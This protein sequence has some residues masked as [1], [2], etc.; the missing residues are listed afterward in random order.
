MVLI[1]ILNRW[2]IL[3][4]LVK[5][6]AAKSPSLG[7]L[8]AE[9]GLGVSFEPVALLGRLAAGRADKGRPGEVIHR[10]GTGAMGADNRPAGARGA[11][12][13]GDAGG[14][15]A[16]GRGHNWDVKEG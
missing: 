6:W 16:V 5:G 1:T 7:R 3:R 11:G 15:G 10:E 14:T 9:V 8:G 12:G 4:I 2:R 13:S